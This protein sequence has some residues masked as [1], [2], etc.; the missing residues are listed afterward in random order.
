MPIASDFHAATTI[1]APRALSPSAGMRCVL[2][3]RVRRAFGLKQSMARNAKSNPRA[4]WRACRRSEPASSGGPF[5]LARHMTEFSSASSFFG[6]RGRRARR[7][8]ERMR[9][10]FPRGMSAIGFPRTNKKTHYARSN[11][12]NERT[13]R[14]RRTLTRSS[15]QRLP[16]RSMSFKGFRQIT[17]RS[18]TDKVRR[19]T[20]HRPTRGYSLAKQGLALPKKI[21]TR[22]SLA[23]PALCKPTQSAR[24][25]V[26]RCEHISAHA[27]A[28]ITMAW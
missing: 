27:A 4:R 3:W 11:A 14:T 2:A 20:N 6:L 1:G 28:H 19:C 9:R 15:L 24:R 26:G 18:S 23:R 16:R 12:A 22:G 13:R 5:S 25:T 7:C 21:G 17:T 8:P 10:V